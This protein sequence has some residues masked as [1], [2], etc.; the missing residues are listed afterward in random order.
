MHFFQLFT[1]VS[2]LDNNFNEHT[3]QVGRE[4]GRL[5]L[6][7]GIVVVCIL[8]AIS[9]L[10]NVL[11]NKKGKRGTTKYIRHKWLIYQTVGV[12]FK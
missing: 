4:L 1:L 10:S 12:N 2:M 3:D 6:I 8:M 9:T 11:S 5:S 7:T